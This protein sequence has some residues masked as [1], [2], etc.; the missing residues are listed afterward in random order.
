MGIRVASKA[1]PGACFAAP[2]QD[3]VV[4]V[5]VPVSVKL[6][7]SMPTKQTDGCHAVCLSVAIKAV[8]LSPSTTYDPV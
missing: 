1:K 8:N 3:A 7:T 2:V 4:E 6:I 5:D